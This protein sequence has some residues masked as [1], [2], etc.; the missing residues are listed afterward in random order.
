[1]ED[2]TEKLLND[3]KEYCKKDFVAMMYN[4]LI[5]PLNIYAYLDNQ[6]ILTIPS[7]EQKNMLQTEHY[8]TLENAFSILTNKKC[9]LTIIEEKEIP[10][11]ASIISNYKQEN[12]TKEEYSKTHLNKDYTFNN[13]VVGESNR[14]AFATAQA[15]AKQPSSIYNPLFIYGGPGLGKT[16]LMHAIGNKII[17]VNPKLNV[18]YVTSEQFLNELVNSIKDR[19]EKSKIFRNKYR[20]IDI[21][22]MDDVQFLSG[23]E[24][25][26]LELYNTFNELHQNKK[27]VVFSADKPPKDIPILEERLRSRFTWGVLVD[28]GQPDYETRLAILK[29]KT[30]QKN[31]IVDEHIL[32]VIAEKINTNIRDLEGVLNKVV[33]SASLIEAPITIEIVEKAINEISLQRENIKTPDL[34]INI[35]ANYFNIKP[36]EIYSSKKS[37]KIVFPRQI[38]MYLCR[39]ELSLPY[40]KISAIFKKKDHTTIMHAEKKIEDEIEM[41]IN[42]K[43][44]VESV[45]NILNNQT[46]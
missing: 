40:Q 27:Q 46:Y 18:L 25:A 34:I 30:E 12:I 9:E 11:Y 44:I 45:K 2:S 26:Q 19:G 21:F 23:K 10:I 37:N 32:S 41:D 1:M 14:L 15:I 6:I 43:L 8:E 31:I 4:L 17:E 29:K 22:L 38:A 39:K 16:H 28:I 3:V 5:E 33:I 24:A 20:N 35:V 42:T 36:E 13:F 7:S